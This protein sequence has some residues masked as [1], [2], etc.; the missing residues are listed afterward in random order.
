MNSTS[1]FNRL[2]TRLTAAFILSAVIGVVLVALLA[3]RYTSSDFSSFLH[4]IENMQGMMGG[5]MGNQT[6]REIEQ[7][8]R[9]NL[10][11]TL[12]IAGI[13]GLVFAI[14][15]SAVIT[16]QIVAPLSKAAAAA[17]RVAQGDFKQIVDIG[18]PAEFNQLG[19][20]FNSMAATLER[21]KQL[22]RNMV[23]DIAHELRTPLTVL[24]GNVEA[25]LDGVIPA[26]LTHLTSLHQETLLLARL[27]EDLRTLSLAEAGQL[28]FRPKPVNLKN[29]STQ[30][31]G[32][33]RSLLNSKNINAEIEG[34]DNLPEI[35]VDPERTAQA[36]RNLV[37]NA[38]HYT[39]EGGSIHIVMNAENDGV[40]LSVADTGIGIAPEDLP[41]LFDR[42]FR[43][44]RSRTRITGGSGLGLAI[45]KQLIE[46]QG[47]RVWAES[48]P[49]KGS[50]FSFWLPRATPCKATP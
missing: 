44:D 10:R 1:F 31:I 9:G 14:V 11:Q 47:G 8:F 24:Q 36:L 37:N 21:D 50:T 35:N 5:M 28:E 12:W 45:V 13:A 25:M 23:A 49:G 17:G 42:F 2:S 34:S 7:D 18:G 46:A 15:L 32:S 22:R 20:A 48:T 29:L 27:V 43:V 16:R 3:Y 40:K 39:P 41:R 26:D 19:Q 6:V 38:I 33:F 4:H 30:M